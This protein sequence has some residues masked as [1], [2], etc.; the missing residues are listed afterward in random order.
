[1]QSTASLAVP[2]TG[3]AGLL[4]PT[5]TGDLTEQSWVTGGSAATHVGERETQGQVTRRPL[6]HQLDVCLWAICLLPPSCQ[7]LT[8]CQVTQL[9]T[10]HVTHLDRN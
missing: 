8:T 3:Q 10:T 1:M 5:L 7:T 6:G 9:V 2:I 4:T